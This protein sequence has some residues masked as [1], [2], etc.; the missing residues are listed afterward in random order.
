MLACGSDEEWMKSK[1]G[2]LVVLKILAIVSFGEIAI[3]SFSLIYSLLARSIIYLPA[4]TYC[5][6]IWLGGCQQK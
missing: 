1:S 6:L 4:S 5:D 2:L 3:S